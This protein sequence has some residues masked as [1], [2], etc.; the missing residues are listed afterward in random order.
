MKMKQKNTT[1]KAKKQNKGITLIALVITIIVLLILAGVTIAT[2]TGD[3]GLLTKAGEAKNASEKANI[4]EKVQLA[5]NEWQITKNINPNENFGNVLRKQFSSEGESVKGENFPYSIVALSGNKEVYLSVSE[6]G[7]IGYL[8]QQGNNGNG[9]Q[10][11]LYDNGLLEIT[12]NGEIDAYQ[13]YKDYKDKIK[14]VKI[15]EGITK[16]NSYA[17]NS[18]NNIEKLSLPDTI[19]EIGGFSFVGAQIDSL[20]IP[21]NLNSIGWRA[22]YNCTQLTKIEIKDLNKWLCAN[23][24]SSVFENCPTHELILNGKKVTSVTYPDNITSTG[25]SLMYCSGITNIVLPNSITQIGYFR[26]CIDLQNI[27]IPENVTMFSSYGF[28]RCSK[29]SAINVPEGV[30]E[31][32]NSLF[33]GCSKLETIT[34]PAAI[35]KIGN[36]T[37]QY[38]TGLTNVTFKGTPQIIDGACFYNT[39][40]RKFTINVPWS[41]GEVANAP[42]SANSAT[43]NYNVQT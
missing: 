5:L 31:L 1:E 16:I 10:W 40:G 41:E 20:N 36:R 35:N 4:H 29:L 27:N 3:N 37:F 42:W 13:Q 15:G 26:N 32:P 7:S 34:I 18:Y 28:A 9:I 43:I 33:D 11:V 25:N 21:A 24:S 6:D 17:F 8:E 2:L 39:A 23:I 19:T 30:T 22:F 14:S 38:C 12:G